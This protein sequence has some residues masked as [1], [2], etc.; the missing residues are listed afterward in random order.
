MKRVIK[1]AAVSAVLAVA[2]CGSF[3]VTTTVVAQP[4]RRVMAEAETFSLLWTSPLP[5]ETMSYLLDDLLDQCGG[6]DLTGVTVTTQIAWAV[7]G[8]KEKMLVTGYCVE[9]ET[10]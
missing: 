4:G 2:G 8:Q 10:G 5:V 3:P 7:I 1:T 9:P 6:A